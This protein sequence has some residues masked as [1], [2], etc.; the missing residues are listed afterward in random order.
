MKNLLLYMAI[1]FL[2]GMNEVASQGPSQSAT[3]EPL[4]ITIG[5]LDPK[6]DEKEVTVKFTV[7]GLDGVSQRILPGQAPTFIIDTK[8]ERDNKRLTVWIEGELANVMDRMQM[9]FRQSNQLKIDTMIVATGT[10]Q[11][12]IDR[13]NGELY[14][15]TVKEW[16]KFRIVIPGTSK[17]KY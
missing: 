9:S 6:M 2:A 15:L 1:G 16:K 13:K 7:A 10:L 12:H 14:L 5:E 8:S 3:K 17:G 4:P 11:I